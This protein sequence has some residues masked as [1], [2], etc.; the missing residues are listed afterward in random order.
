MSFYVYLELCMFVEEAYIYMHMLRIFAGHCGSL[1][2][3]VKMGFMD[4]DL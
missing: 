3:E 2:L 1:N 4:L